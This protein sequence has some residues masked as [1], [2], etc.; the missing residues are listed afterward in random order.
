MSF[1]MEIEVKQNN[2][3]IVGHM[4]MAADGLPHWS[5][6]IKPAPRIVTK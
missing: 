6:A 4:A 5:T 3:E 1:M 2:I